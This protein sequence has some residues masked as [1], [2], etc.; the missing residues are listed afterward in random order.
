[1]LAKRGLARASRVHFRVVISVIWIAGGVMAAPFAYGLRVTKAPVPYFPLNSCS[2]TR[3]MEIFAAFEES[4]RTCGL[5]D[6][7]TNSIGEPKE[8]FLSIL[9]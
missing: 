9:K 2:E 4:W 3:E 5:R 1:M 8:N 7:L 6:Y